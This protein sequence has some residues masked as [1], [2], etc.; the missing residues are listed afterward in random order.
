MYNLFLI[1]IIVIKYI[2]KLVY[3]FTFLHFFS[4]FIKY[5]KLFFF[6]E[7][8]YLYKPTLEPL[9]HLS[10]GYIILF[11]SDLF[12]FRNISRLAVFIQNRVKSPNQTPL[13]KNLLIFLLRLF[14]FFIIVWLVGIP[15]LVLR[16]LFFSLR[17]LTIK[18]KFYNFLK[19]ELDRTKIYKIKIL[20]YSISIYSL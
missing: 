7:A 4:I 15:F 9:Q 17:N 1:N 16:F 5:I 11:W 2:L 13:Y 12:L 20:A 8:M 3:C 19:D 6:N 14:L 18:K 10:L